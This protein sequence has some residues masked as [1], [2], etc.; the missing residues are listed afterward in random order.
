M[1]SA[2]TLRAPCRGMDGFSP[3]E[4]AWKTADGL[5]RLCRPQLQVCRRCPFRAECIALVKPAQAQFDGVAGG[6][7]WCNGEVIARLSSVT[8]ADMAEPKLRASC[9]TEAG[10]KD[11]NRNGERACVSCRQVARQIHA[12]RKEERA[13]EEQQEQL[14][15]DFTPAA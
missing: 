15:L 5:K 7:V 4:K 14:Q 11:H 6:R 10:A 2:W 9:G 12:R 3:S 1:S 13:K 8:D